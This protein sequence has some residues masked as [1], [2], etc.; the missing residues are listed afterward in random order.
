MDDLDRLERD[1]RALLD[2]ARVHLSHGE[3]GSASPALHEA[4]IQF[5]R[6]DASLS[7]RAEGAAER[8]RPM[9]ADACRMYGE[10]LMA[11]DRPAESARI[12]QEATDLYG[13]MEGEE[14]QGL[15]ARCARNILINISTLRMQPERRLEL[16]IAH[17]ERLLE[18]IELEQSSQMRQAECCLHIAR[19]LTR[20]DRPGPATEWFGRACGLYEQCANSREARLGEA[21]CHHRTAVLLFQ[22]LDDVTAAADHYR[23]A[24]ALYREYEEPIYGL[25]HSYDLCSAGLREAEAFIDNARF[26]R[27][28]RYGSNL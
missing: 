5:S 18:Q 14:M 2:S 21:E 7:E 26:T 10:L 25:R 22:E 27:Q 13:A 3:E 12:L 28:N 23:Q 20:R 6:L 24:I 15:A 11:Q 1:A 19:I 8:I 9:R 4:V 16:L 17:Y